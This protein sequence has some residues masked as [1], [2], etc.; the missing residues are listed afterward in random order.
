MFL[1]AN[2]MVPLTMYSAMDLTASAL[3]KM[4]TEEVEPSLYSLLFQQVTVVLTMHNH[5]L[6]ANSSRLIFSHLPRIP[7]SIFHG[8][9]LLESILRSS[10][11]YRM[12]SAGV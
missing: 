8:A 5:L 2:E 10:V 1:D 11:V 3:T 6:L 4:E 12:T 9:A 7:A